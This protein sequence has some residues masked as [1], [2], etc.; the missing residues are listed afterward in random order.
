MATLLITIIYAAFIG[1]GL[2]DS[3]FGASWPSIYT[4]FDLPI[5]LGGLVT[6]ICCGATLISSLMSSRLIKRL[7][8]NKLTAACTLLTAVSLL[9]YSFAPH[10]V[11]ICL[12]AVPL[13]LGA[14]SIDTAL[15]NYVALHYSAS[16]MSFLHCC[17][18]VGVTISPF[19][20]SQ[21]FRSGMTW[22]TGY[23]IMALVQFALAM[24]LVF[25]L[26]VWKKVHGGEESSE[27]DFETLSLRQ[28]ASIR[29]VKVM[30]LLFM[31]SC[32]IECSVGNW[33]STFLVE[34]KHLSNEIAAA[35]VTFYYLGMTMGRFL[36]G[37]LAKKLHSWQ[38]IKIGFILLGA[39]LVLLVLVPVNAVTVVALM[40]IGLG[41]GPMFPNFNYLAP[42]NFGEKRSPA[43]IGTQMAVSSFAILVGPVV[44]GLLGQAFGMRVFP[45]YLVTFYAVMVAVFIRATR[46]WQMRRILD[47]KDRKEKL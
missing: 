12:L 26:P 22:R 43:I 23:R 6:S 42:E 34:H 15:N 29:G 33:G 8:T 30:W 45:F 14:G 3:L 27:E 37:L 21:V 32:T 25:T 10:F 35:S 41:N 13:G 4:E 40:L 20:L 31:C 1:L 28:A 17:Y 38:I 19:V 46:I 2:P 9:G 44:C 7:G 11:F 47:R 39:A 36:S 5:S 16:R 24:L 18:G